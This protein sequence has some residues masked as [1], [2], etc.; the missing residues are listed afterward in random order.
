MIVFIWIFL[1]GIFCLGFAFGWN[2]REIEE[3]KKELI[4]KIK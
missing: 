4:N 1:F 3:R 2:W